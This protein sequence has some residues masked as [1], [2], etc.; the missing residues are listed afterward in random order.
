[1]VDPRI[2]IEDPKSV[3]Q[4]VR[5]DRTRMFLELRSLEKTQWRLQFKILGV[6]RAFCQLT[7]GYEVIPYTLPYTVHYS[8]AD[9][10]PKA[11]IILHSLVFH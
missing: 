10:T 8:A 3:M 2:R 1:M 9:R 7:W 11:D 5:S 4:Q 6:G